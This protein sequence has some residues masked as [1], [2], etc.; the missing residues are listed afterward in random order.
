[1]RFCSV[2]QTRR[3]FLATAAMA[4]AAPA[5]QASAP[6][7]D[8]AG[9]DHVA[10]PM[11]NTE[12]VLAFYRKLRFDVV[13]AKNA[14]FVYVGEQMISFHKPALS[15]RPSFTLR[16]T[17]AKPGCGDLCFVWSGK[18][19]SLNAL[20][21]HAGAKIVEGPVPREG[22]RRKAGSSVYTRDPDGNL[23]EFLIYGSE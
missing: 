19:E 16:G 20:L 6:D 5:L 7:A 12:A 9:F 14:A 17:A 13:E 11:E 22:G 15:R 4:A 1:M 3:Q 8:V 18:P 21:E 10:L 2:N 23:L